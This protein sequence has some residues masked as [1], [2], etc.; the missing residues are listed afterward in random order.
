MAVIIM[1]QKADNMKEV[2]F[3]KK[4]T[5]RVIFDRNLLSMLR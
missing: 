2:I 5:Q 3:N 1:G 4:G